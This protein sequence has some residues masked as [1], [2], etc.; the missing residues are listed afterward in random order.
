MFI[1]IHVFSLKF[2]SCLFYLLTMTVTAV[3]A[4]GAE[5]AWRTQR[6][7]RPLPPRLAV[8]LPWRFHIDQRRHSAAFVPCA[9]RML[10]YNA[11]THARWRGFY[12]VLPRL[13]RG[14]ALGLC[15]TSRWL[16]PRISACLA[17]FA[18]VH[19]LVRTGGWK[20]WWNLDQNDCG[21][22]T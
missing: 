19:C 5:R 9:L 20:Y 18:G 1:Y 15:L 17:A 16:G 8:C 3:A 11:I 6:V 10:R 7:L 13:R 4:C 2:I 22:D 12:S 14:L 21:F